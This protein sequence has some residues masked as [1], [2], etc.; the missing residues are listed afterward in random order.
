MNRIKEYGPTLLIFVILIICLVFSYIYN[1]QSSQDD[2]QIVELENVNVVPTLISELNGNSMWAPTF[3]LI[4]NDLKNI[5]VKGEVIFNNDPDNQM[6]LDL[7]EETFKEVDINDSYYYKKYGFMT[8]ELK[9]EI[10]EAIKEKFNEKSDILDD[11]EFTKESNDYFFY[12][13]LVKEFKFL[14]PFDILDDKTFGI[15]SKSSSELYK[16]V[17]ILFYEGK[18]NYAVKLFTQNNDE[19]ILYKGEHKSTFLD[20]YQEIINKTSKEDFISAD[21]L[22]VSNLNFK[23]KKSF[24]ELQGK[25]FKTGDSEFIIGKTL[26]MI[27][28][29]MNNEG[30]K[31]KSEAGMSV[32]EYS[33]EPGRYFDFTDKFTLFIKEIDRD[34]PYF[35]LLIDDIDIY[36]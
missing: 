35:A 4:W 31:V 11:F 16:N 5:L 12:S 3:Q 33:A 34:L 10:E 6:V 21:V 28:F 22:K 36:Q 19:V 18:N 9:K 25:N 1:D 27:Q 24:T 30:G 7:N 29:K 20:T 2:N 8:L 15:D 17:S 14:K 13:M 23:I 32:K 26:Q